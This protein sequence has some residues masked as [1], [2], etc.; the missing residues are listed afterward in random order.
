MICCIVLLSGAIT[1]APQSQAQ[2]KTNLICCQ[3]QN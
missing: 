2:H 1:R 3:H